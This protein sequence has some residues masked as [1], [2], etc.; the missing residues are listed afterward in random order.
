MS[1]ESFSFSRRLEEAAGPSSGKKEDYSDLGFED[2][3]DYGQHL[4]TI[5]ADGIFIPAVDPSRPS[6]PMLHS[7]LYVQ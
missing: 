3:Y 4:R 7:I 5:K 6:G 2:D 1:I